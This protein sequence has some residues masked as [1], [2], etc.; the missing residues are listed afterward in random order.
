[1]TRKYILRGAEVLEVEDLSAWGVWFETADR[2]VAETWIT[3]TMQVSTVF[4]GLDHQW[5]NGPPLLFETMVFQ[6]GAG[7]DC[8]RYPTYHAAEQGH[9][10]VVRQERARLAERT[11]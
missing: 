7:G 11:A 5:G 3:E 4:L 6:D 10:Q 9:E 1:M 2:R 8:Q